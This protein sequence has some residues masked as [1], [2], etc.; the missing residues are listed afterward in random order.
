MNRKLDSSPVHGPNM[1]PIFD[2]RNRS[3]SVPARFIHIVA[4]S[5]GVVA[6]RMLVFHQCPT[7]RWLFLHVSKGRFNAKNPPPRKPAR[8]LES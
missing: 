3:A 4:L 7:T 2:S 1:S 6:P 5:L 8:R